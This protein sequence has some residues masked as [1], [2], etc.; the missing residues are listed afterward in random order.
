MVPS[1]NS[2]PPP[3]NALKYIKL[4]MAN[5]FETV[6]KFALVPLLVVLAARFWLAKV[7]ATVPEPYLVRKPT[8]EKKLHQLTGAK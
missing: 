2:T 1:N 7:T 5:L 6:Y 8:N 4:Q 3:E